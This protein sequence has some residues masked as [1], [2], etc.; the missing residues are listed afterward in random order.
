[1]LKLLKVARLA[2]LTTEIK[3]ALLL[4]DRRLKYSL[5]IDDSGYTI[6]GKFS[7]QT[8]ETLTEETSI[9]FTEDDNS[10]IF[11]TYSGKIILY[12]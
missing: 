5:T 6:Q 7:E 2:A 3:A 9:P 1:M 12:R 4:L 10:V 8:F 11:S